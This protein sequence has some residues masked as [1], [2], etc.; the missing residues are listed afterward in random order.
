MASFHTR[1]TVY[2][3]SMLLLLDKAYV[4]KKDDSINENIFFSFAKGRQ[5][6]SHELCITKKSRGV[7]QQFMFML[8]ALCKRQ[9]KYILWH[10]SFPPIRKLVESREHFYLGEQ[11][12][13]MLN[14]T[15]RNAHT[16]LSYSVTFLTGD[17]LLSFAMYSKCLVSQCAFAGHIIK[18]FVYL[19]VR[20]GD[21]FKRVVLWRWWREWIYNDWN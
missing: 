8:K 2:S 5:L 20:I 14:F 17:F 6:R 15:G 9:K 3:K 11:C 13:V 1:C 21:F 19:F 12:A 18:T 4:Y 16:L 10:A 7:H